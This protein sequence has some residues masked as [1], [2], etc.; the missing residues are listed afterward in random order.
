MSKTNHFI[1]FIGTYFLTKVLYWSF[2]YYPFDNNT[3]I[4]GLLID[5]SIWGVIY[6]SIGWVVDKTVKTKK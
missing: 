4:V 2:N 5:L 1:Q 6:L 3:F